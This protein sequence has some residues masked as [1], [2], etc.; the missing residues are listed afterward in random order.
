MMCTSDVATGGVG[1]GD[2]AAG[3][4]ADVVECSGRC[5]VGEVGV[6]MS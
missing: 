6:G 5:G 2:V 3:D 4:G 1:F